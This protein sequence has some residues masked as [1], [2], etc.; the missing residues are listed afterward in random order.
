MRHQIQNKF[1]EPKLI[2]L[3][4]ADISAGYQVA[5]ALHA[6][7]DF[8]HQHPETFQEWKSVSNSVVALSVPSEKHLLKHFRKLEGMNAKLVMFN[9]PDLNNEATSIGVYGT[10]DIRKKLSGLPLCLGK[11]FN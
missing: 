8:A 5:Q 2:V 3:V 7:A 10:P 9:E 11:D 4:R 6:V 1:Q